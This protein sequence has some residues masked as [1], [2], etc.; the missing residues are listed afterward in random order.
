M[1]PKLASDSATETYLKPNQTS[2][3]ELFCENS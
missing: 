2:T 3:I 1:W